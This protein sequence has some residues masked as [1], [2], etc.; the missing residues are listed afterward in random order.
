MLIF[1][2]RAA[3]GGR[4]AEGQLAGDMANL[5]APADGTIAVDVLNRKM[6]FKNARNGLFDRNGSS[7]ILH[8]CL[9]KHRKAPGVGGKIACDVIR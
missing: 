6:T 4:H 9:D 3:L 5:K 1:S 8:A 2:C 7:L